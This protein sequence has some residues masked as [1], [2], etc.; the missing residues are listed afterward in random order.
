MKVLSFVLNKATLN[1]IRPKIAKM[2][3]IGNDLNVWNILTTYRYRGN[4]KQCQGGRLILYK[5][6]RFE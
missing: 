2:I 6:Y 1:R 4:G 5:L 3:G